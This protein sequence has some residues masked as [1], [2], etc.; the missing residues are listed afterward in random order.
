MRH[1][2]VGVGVGGG[3]GVGVGV[4]WGWGW[5]CVGAVGCVWGV[6]GVC[7]GGGVWGWGWGWVGVGGGGGY[8]ARFTK[9]VWRCPSYRLISDH[10]ER[11]THWSSVR[12]THR[13][14][15]QY[16]NFRTSRVIWT[17]YELVTY[18]VAYNIHLKMMQEDLPWEIIFHL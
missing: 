7:G 1:R 6:C 2:G 5:G 16:F 3:G 15:T 13:A 9:A 17:K 10:I 18:I 11:Y 8:L 14:Q 4:G 12:F